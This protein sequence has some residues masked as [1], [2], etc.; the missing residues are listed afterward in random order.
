MEEH[1]VDQD[2]VMLFVQLFHL[3]SQSTIVTPLAPFRRRVSVWI[4][5]Y[6]CLLPVL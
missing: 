5:G 2:R 6:V 4:C 3:L 1:P